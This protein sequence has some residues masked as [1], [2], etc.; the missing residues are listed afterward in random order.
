LGENYKLLNRQRQEQHQNSSK[1]HNA[2]RQGAP[3]QFGESNLGEYVDR[4][5]AKAIIALAKNYQAGSIV[6]PKLSDVQESIQS[7]VQARAEQKCPELIEAQKKYAKQY[8]SSVHRWSYSRLI[9]S[10]QSQAA[11]AGIIVEEARQSLVV[12]PQ[13]KAKKLAIDA[14]NSRLQAII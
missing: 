10:I 12:S 5:L 11:Q 14:Y 4:L 7:E 2:Q 13:D 9:E 8:R 3:N 6:L 1:R